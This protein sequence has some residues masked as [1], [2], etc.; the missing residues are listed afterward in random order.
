MVEGEKFYPKEE[1]LG[2]DCE[3][4]SLGCD[5]PKVEM[6]GRMSCEG[7]IDSVCIFLKEGRRVEGFDLSDA[8]VL[9]LKITPPGFGS[10][11]YSIPAGSPIE[12]L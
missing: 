9:K 3:F 10:P 7:V 5:Y 11:D 4:W 6:Q 2:E 8:Q 1:N 12:I